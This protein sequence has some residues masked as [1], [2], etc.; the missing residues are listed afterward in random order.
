MV[1]FLS[2]CPALQMVTY[3][4]CPYVLE[5]ERN[6]VSFSSYKDTNS[7]LRAPLSWPHLNLIPPKG[8]HLH[9]PSHQG[10]GLQYKH[11]WK[12]AN[13]Q[14]ITSSYPSIWAGPLSWPF[15]LLSFCCFWPPHL[16]QTYPWHDMNLFW[17]INWIQFSLHSL[18]PEFRHPLADMSTQRRENWLSGSALASMCNIT[19]VLE[20]EE[21]QSSFSP[22]VRFATFQ[23]NT[24]GEFSTS[25][26]YELNFQLPSTNGEEGHK[27]TSVN[28][29]KH[30]IWHLLTV[31]GLRC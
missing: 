19:Y 16:C 20:P 6:L 18:N 1:G 5:R 3:L 27:A 23:T 11:F 7:I 9:I 21:A 25:N 22:L 17:K 2:Y 10:L 28:L 15:I 24:F 29:I 12:D 30:F 31:T 26:S 8:P 13:I 14:S 4:L